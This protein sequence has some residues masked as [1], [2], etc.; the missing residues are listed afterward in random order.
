ML[1][2]CADRVIRH[3]LESLDFT[4]TIHDQGQRRSLHPAH[5]QQGPG[6]AALRPQGVGAGKVHADQPIG[7]CA[8]SGSVGPAVI[9]VVFFQC[10]QA[11]LDR[12]GVLRGNPKAARWLVGLEVVQHFID[13]QLAFTVG[14]ASVDDFARLLD[15]FADHGKLLLRVVLRPQNPRFR[16]DWQL[17]DAPDF[18]AVAVARHVIGRVLVRLGLF[19]HVTKAPGYFVGAAFDVAVAFACDAQRLGN[20][21]RYGWFFS[22]EKS[23]GDPLPYQVMTGRITVLICERLMGPK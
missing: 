18:F 7:A 2:R 8:A 15:E 3:R 13:Q 14:V 20:G 21:F 23:H 19:Q 10:G 17:F 9:S 4:V 11:P 12:H 6:T 5:G 1:N 22:D 16:D